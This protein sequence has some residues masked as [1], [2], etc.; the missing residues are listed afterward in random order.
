MAKKTLV[1]S[2]VACALLFAVSTA[3]ASA[4]TVG[5]I[6]SQIQSLLSKIT[7]LTNQLNILR[8]QSNTG[9]G[10]TVGPIETVPYKHRICSVVWRNLSQGTQGDDVTSLQEFLRDEGYLSANATGY[11]GTLTAQAVA[12]WQSAEGVSAVGHFGPMSRERIKI[13]CGGGGERLRAYPMR[14]SAPLS[15]TFTSNVQLPGPFVQDAGAYKIVFGDGQEQNLSCSPDIYSQHVGQAG[16]GV[17]LSAPFQCQPIPVTHTY[18]ADGT[19][20]ASLVSYGGFCAYPCPETV[21][22]QV[23]I[24]VG[25]I[26]CTREY[27]PVCGRPYSYCPPNA[28]CQIPLPQTYSNR[29][30]MNAAGASF[31]YDGQCRS[32]WKNPADDPQCK[33]WTD[34]LYCGKTCSRTVPGGALECNIA[35]CKAW[36]PENPVPRCL[37]YFS[38]SGNKPPVISGFSGPTTLE[39]NA[40][41]TWTISASDPENQQ[42]SYQ[43][44]WGDERT[45]YTYPQGAMISAIPV[46]V[47]NT[48]FTHAYANAGNYTVTILVQDSSGQ[49]AKTST[50]VK[51]GYGVACTMEYAPVCGQPAWS[52][53][54]GMYCATVMPAP[55]TY[56]N[57]CMMNAAGASFLYEGQCQSGSACTGE[58]APVCGKPSICYQG[59]V[60]AWPRECEYGK[61]Y[62]NR[63]HL[64]SENATYV[65]AGT[66]TG[67]PVY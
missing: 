14:G 7:E 59:H 23:K 8:G 9:V 39:V 22:A 30:L 28:D 3:P 16:A 15:V 57:R 54:A 33:R 4:L 12:K 55:Q 66:C 48:T 29:C 53:P 17:S 21:V 64:N 20:T 38:N 49:S 13:W 24:H 10:V 42:L 58:Y 11:F 36:G 60:G 62:S 37:E 46:F 6:Q 26:A 18:A 45:P 35:S 43:V 41:G 63:C 44:T 61:T 31:L 32:D 2:L 47:Q 40:T 65:Y 19:Y 27:K 25:P 50:T 5:D 52:C 67:A 34:G 56:S 1:G 51:V